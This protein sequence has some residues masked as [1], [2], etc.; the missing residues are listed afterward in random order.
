[1]RCKSALQV[2]VTA[3]AVVER[4]ALPYVYIHEIVGDSHLVWWARAYVAMF[5][6]KLMWDCR[7]TQDWG[8]RVLDWFA[9]HGSLGLQNT[10]L[11]LSQSYQH[12]WGIVWSPLSYKKVL[13]L[14]LLS[15]HNGIRWNKMPSVWPL[16]AII[17]IPL[18]RFAIAVQCRVH[19]SLSWSNSCD[20]H[21]RRQQ[22]NGTQNGTL[23]STLNSI[24]WSAHNI[25][26]IFYHISIYFT[27]KQN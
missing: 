12:H 19:G 3:N 4:E 8:T 21:L 15:Q 23:H 17:T 18:P 11:K 2:Y 5:L 27:K 10:F 1:M 13:Y 22:G 20:W 16:T 9:G 14:T 6:K 25:M 26:S 24:A 7:Y